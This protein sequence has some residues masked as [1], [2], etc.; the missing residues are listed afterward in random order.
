MKDVA[1][2]DG[3]EFRRLLRLANSVA[4]EARRAAEEARRAMEAGQMER[5]EERVSVVEQARRAAEE[6]RRAMAAGQNRVGVEDESE[7]MDISGNQWARIM[8]RNVG[9]PLR[10]IQAEE[11]G[12]DGFHDVVIDGEE[13]VDDE[14]QDL[15]ERYDGVGN[16]DGG[17]FEVWEQDWDV[18][19]DDGTVLSDQNLI[20]VLMP[21]SVLEEGAVEVLMPVWNDGNL[22]IDLTS[23]SGSDGESNED[24]GGEIA[25]VRFPLVIDLTVDDG[26]SVG[27]Y[28]VS[29]GDEDNMEGVTESVAEESSSEEEDSE[30][31]F[32]VADEA[33]NNLA[34]VWG[35]EASID[36]IQQIERMLLN[37]WGVYGHADCK[38]E[39]GES[40]LEGAGRGVFVRK[41]CVIHHGECITEYSGRVIR[42]ARHLNV[43]EQ[44]R[45][46]QV[47]R[48][49][50]LGTVN[51]KD[52]EG[53]GSIV[54]SSVVGRTH[55]FARFVTY[56]G[57]IYMMAHIEKD[58]YPLR[59]SMELYLTAGHAWW[60]LFNSLYNV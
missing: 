10:R 21:V 13:E 2:D 58:Q 48:V 51:L 30:E 1:S 33:A 27:D 11:K 15:E 45:T 5:D 18:E 46:M 20:E 59:G 28:D 26:K 22:V 35:G 24:T 43:E 25:D 60:S 29:D 47:G 8:G 4:E 17:R 14:E 41:G 32:V 23:E 36:D 49:I 40:L 9:S 19:S 7:Q 42:T 54:N 55:S 12:K 57:A 56:N 44:L 50:V 16:A 6:A 34:T 52:G 38:L 53:F 39:V 31:Q 37:G 3:T